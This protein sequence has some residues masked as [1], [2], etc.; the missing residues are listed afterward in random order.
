MKAHTKLVLRQM[1]GDLENADASASQVYASASRSF[2]ESR[3]LL[4][5]VKSARGYFP[6]V[7]IGAFE[8]LAHPSTDRKL[9]TSRGKGKNGKENPLIRKMESRHSLVHLEFCRSHTHHVQS[10]VLRCPRNVRKKRVCRGP[11]HTPRLRP[12]QCMLCRQVGHRVS[13]CPDNG[14]ATTIFPRKRAFGT[15][16]LD[17]AVF[18][19][20]VTGQQLKKLNKIKTGETSNSLWRFQ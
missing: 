2:Q 1:R 19:P 15:Y 14:K 6:V 17:C 13:V 16:A 3:E 10:L 5:R 20:R 4:T 7:G 9:A 8:S 11:L 18:D 12:D